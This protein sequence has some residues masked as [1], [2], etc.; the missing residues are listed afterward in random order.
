MKT[1]NKHIKTAI[2]I[3]F[4]GFFLTTCDSC[5]PEPKPP[6]QN[7]YIPDS[8][9]FPMQTGDT[10]IFMVKSADTIRYDTAVIAVKDTMDAY[11]TYE[12]GFIGYSQSISVTYSFNDKDSSRFLIR[13]EYQPTIENIQKYLFF[14]YYNKNSDD[15]ICEAVSNYSNYIVLNKFV[16]ENKEYYNVI[17]STTCQ[18]IDG[19]CYISDIYRNIE[20]GLLCFTNVNTLDNFSMYKYTAIK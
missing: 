13:E 20:N 12:Y 16:L 5:K 3:V 1:K 4:A 9:K 19:S 15:Y 10:A 6:K 14:E 17:Y 11:V 7:Y 18:Q 2:I 8:L